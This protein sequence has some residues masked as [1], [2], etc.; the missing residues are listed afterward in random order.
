MTEGTPSYTAFD[1]DIDGATGGSGASNSASVSKKAGD[2]GD[3]NGLLWGYK[4]TPTT[5]TYSFPTS[6]AEYIS[7]GYEA[8]NGFQAFN[9]AQQTAVTRL[10]N[11]VAAVTGLGF[12]LTTDTNA[13]LR[14]AMVDTL[15]SGTGDALHVPGGSNN[16]AEATP[17]DPDRF[18]AYAFGDT[19][20][21]KTSYNAPTPGSFGYAAGIAHEI[22]HALGLKH[23]HA[24]QT[25]HAEVFPELPT[26]HDSQEYSIMTYNTWPE[27]RSKYNDAD[28]P[29]GLMQDDIAALQYLYGADFT[30]NAGD[31]RYTWSLTSGRMSIDGVPIDDA[32]PARNMI[33]QTIWDGGGTDTYDFSNYAQALV[34]DLRPGAWTTLSEAA[35]N[36]QRAYLGIADDGAPLNFARGNIAN[37]LLYDG[38]VRS[39]IE[40]AVGGAGADALTGNA[41]DNVLEGGAGGD[42]LDGG[43]GADTASYRSSD[44]GVDVDLSRATLLP[45]DAQYRA[46]TGG[47]AAG[48]RLISIENLIGSGLDDRL[49]GYG[50]LSGS[51]I[52]AGKGNDTVFLGAGTDVARG[53][54]GNDTITDSGGDDVLYGGDS[55]LV[56][57]GGFEVVADPT[58]DANGYGYYAPL[59]GWQR[60]AGPGIELFTGG[61][62][63]TPSEGR[64]GVDLEG[65]QANTNAM[66]T[67][68]IAGAEDGAL[69]RLA[70]DARK[71]G[72]AANARLEVY[73]GA[74]K[75]NWTIGAATTDYIDPGTATLVYYID[76]TGGAGTGTDKNRLTFKEVGT[77]DAH[78]TLIDNVRLYR[79]E[80]GTAKASDDD[81]FAD[82]NDVLTPGTGADT[83]FGHGGD[84]T[85]TISDLDGNADHVD[86]GSGTDLLVMNWSAATSAITY[87]GLGTSDSTAFGQAERYVLGSFGQ[88]LY[89]KEI[90]RFHLSG[91][92]GNDALNGGG[93][94]DILIG[95]RGDD[96]LN[97]GGG[98]DD[99]D[100]GEG[101]DRALVALS[102]SGNN[103]VVLQQLQ[104]GGTLTLSNG[105]RLTS[106]EAIDLLAGDGNDLLDVRG[107]VVNAAG[108]AS[109]DPAFAR[110]ATHFAGKGGDDTLMVDLATS[111]GAS[112]DGGA[113]TGD[114]L[115]M[116]WSRASSAIFRDSGDGAYKSYSHTVTVVNHGST[117][118]FYS[119][120]FTGVERFDLTGGS[121]N[122]TLIGGA[123]NDRLNGGTGSDTLTADAGLDTL[124]LD[125]S[126]Y[127]NGYGVGGGITGGTLGAGYGGAFSVYNSNYAATFTGVERFDLALTTVA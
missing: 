40:N 104:G 74:Q 106:I 94:N 15:D 108:V 111:Y 18:P 68:T 16:S 122:D 35:R 110:T 9:T 34:V 118:Y 75:L 105:T 96:T 30:T 46:P 31:S 91:G 20:F 22:G 101:F 36:T 29:I 53:G 109:T 60:L 37:A 48:D 92:T 72:T 119:A 56:V 71:I 39:L 25:T 114:L 58:M 89:F 98:V 6:S 97:G 115:V 45:G 125:W 7:N 5:L 8:V 50:A 84:D 32:D 52:D 61:A 21:N 123:G 28:Y 124:V 100:G 116:D 67:Q 26:D 23:G 120:S 121:A 19:W 24:A 102:G 11:N 38:D 1:H 51:A 4:W 27:G 77:G 2:S 44:V 14:F 80:A 112:F 82:G 90:E 49:V 79:V 43:E 33:F 57:N 47:H 3:I 99:I 73:W 42:T 103:T 54:L 78:G 55:N 41:A 93:L 117:E 127:A 10:L 81:P 88:T 69:Y 70:F 66:I 86:G 126:S 95:N 17:P 83:V 87:V 59:D 113:G 63:G 13:N 65:N 12:T 85:V 107:T 62:A 76:L 64:Y